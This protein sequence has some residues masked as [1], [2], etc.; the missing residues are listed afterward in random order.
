MRKKQEKI[1]SPKKQKGLLTGGAAF[2]EYAGNIRDFRHIIEVRVVLTGSDR[3]GLLP[4]A[5]RGVP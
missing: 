1:P 4:H 3:N 2:F 5:E